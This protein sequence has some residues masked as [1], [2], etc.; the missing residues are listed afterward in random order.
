MPLILNRKHVLEIYEE[1]YE[2]EWVL[3]TFNTE[4]LTTSEAVLSAVLEYG[5]QI[6]QDNLPI[7]IG[8]TNKYN[9]RPQSVYYTLTRQW[10]I[11]L[12]LFLEDL[13]VLTSPESPFASLRVMVHLDHIQW[14]HD[15]EL[16][17]SGLSRFSSIMYDASSLP[18][19]EN[20]IKTAS[21]VEQH[22]DSIYIEGACDE[23]SEAADSSDNELTAP[24]VAEQYFHETGVDLIVA[25]LGTEHRTSIAALHYN[26]ELAKKITQLIGKRLCL[27]GTS[28][29]QPNQIATL[30]S[31]GVRKANVWTALERDSSPT[32]F[33]DMLNN[34]AKIIGAET[35]S[36]LVKE[37]LLGK[38][39]D[40]ISAIS[41]NY[42]TTTYRQEI[43][44]HQMKKIVTNYLQAWYV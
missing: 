15:E 28:S 22:G 34:A 35:A 36:K 11:G 24:E 30:F 38:N 17:K 13:R 6:G 23:I 12:G 14:D 32:L 43:L 44:F 1:A 5:E 21:F 41:I 7:I 2:R 16:I 26:N 42:C 10:Q 39:A 27:H 40:Y 4:N 29:V 9:K 25:N 3:P 8:I 20:I 33:R 31:D 18:L 37:E 19:E